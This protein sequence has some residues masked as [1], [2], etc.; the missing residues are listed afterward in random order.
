MCCA[1]GAALGSAVIGRPP[2]W[3]T[4]QIQAKVEMVETWT[5]WKKP[6]EEEKH[7]KYIKIH[8]NTIYMEQSWGEHGR[9]TG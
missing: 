6:K 8:Q 3:S 7:A 4:N 9:A 1:V 2:V 5:K